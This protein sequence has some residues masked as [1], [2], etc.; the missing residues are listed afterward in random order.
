MEKAGQHI[1]REDICDAAMN[2]LDDMPMELLKNE[3]L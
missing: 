2:E 1:Q 3:K